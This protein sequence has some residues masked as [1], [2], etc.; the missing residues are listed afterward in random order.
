MNPVVERR[1]LELPAQSA[2]AK[3]GPSVHVEEDE[4]LKVI[5]TGLGCSLEVPKNSLKIVV[6]LADS[7]N[8]LGYVWA[9]RGH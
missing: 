4:F 7:A 2:S 5:Y 1:S 3:F 9:G 8:S 6:V